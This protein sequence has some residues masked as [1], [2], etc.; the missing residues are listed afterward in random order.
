ML[1]KV[2]M[3][4]ADWRI[5]ISAFDA[6]MHLCIE[7]FNC[8]LFSHPLLLPDPLHPQHLRFVAGAA[9]RRGL[10]K[11]YIG[12]KLKTDLNALAGSSLMWCH[13]RYVALADNM[14]H[15]LSRTWAARR[16]ECEIKQHFCHFLC[17]LINLPLFFPPRQK[18]LLFSFSCLCAGCTIRNLHNEGSYAKWDIQHIP[19]NTHKKLIPA[20]ALKN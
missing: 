7:I 17:F 16:N 6:L 4:S 13:T 9:S 15:E 14:L 20:I 12:E 1:S 8:K 18:S 11:I 19:D 10:M 5:S 3:Q 2:W